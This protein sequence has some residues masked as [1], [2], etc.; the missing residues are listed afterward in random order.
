MLGSNRLATTL[1]RLSLAT[2]IATFT[3][4]VSGCS[5]TP[6]VGGS[7]GGGPDAA[8]DASGPRDSG[9][10]DAA[11]PDAARA[12]LNHRP[13][14]SQCSQPA[15]VGNCPVMMG[16]GACMS[17][18]QCNMGVNGRCSENMGGALFCYCAY[19]SCGHDA[20]CPA[21]QLCVC[22]GS[23]YAGGGGNTCMAGNCRVD[24]DCGAGGYCSPTHGTNGCGSVSGYYC[25]TSADT[26]VDDGDCTGTM[27]FEVCAWSTTDNHWKCQQPNLCG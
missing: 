2:C 22:H 13:D 7:D 8:G 24:R 12:P 14:D 5:S 6:L 17:D 10:H 15:P 11:S 27:G 23:A 20:D 16:S 26:C 19:D 21:G 4:A 3:M 9:G 18:A 1:A 25:H